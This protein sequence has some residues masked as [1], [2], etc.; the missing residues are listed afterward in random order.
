ME[1]MLNSATGRLSDELALSCL[2]LSSVTPSCV[3]SPLSKVSRDLSILDRRLHRESSRFTIF[4]RSPADKA[5]SASSEPK[6]P[7]I[8][9]R[10]S[11]YEQQRSCR[12]S[13]VS[14]LTDEDA[15]LVPLVGFETFL[16]QRINARPQ[17]LLLPLLLTQGILLLPQSRHTVPQSLTQ[18]HLP[19]RPRDIRTFG[20]T[21]L[22]WGLVVT[23]E[24]VQHAY[25][26]SVDVFLLL[27]IQIGLLQ[28]NSCCCVLSSITNTILDSRKGTTQFKSLHFIS[29]FLFMGLIFP[30]DLSILG[31]IHL[32]TTLSDCEPQ[33]TVQ[34]KIKS[35]K[36]NQAKPSKDGDLGH[37]YLVFH[38]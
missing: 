27:L 6:P 11:T 19:A 31:F 35:K 20:F 32:N 17:R 10:T 22:L 16:H 14:C 36:I 18:L 24:Y 21:L 13:Q 15:V 30:P 33:K 29:F 3:S 7:N 4:S 5:K 28:L 1:G 8:N 2:T 34:I 23:T 26:L 38:C 9:A 12:E 37:L 25:L